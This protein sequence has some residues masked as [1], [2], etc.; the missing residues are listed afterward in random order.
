MVDRVIKILFLAAN[1]AST[2]RLTLDVEAR[3]IEQKLRESRHR[4]AFRCEQRWAVTPSD[5]QHALLDVSPD[6][7]HFSGHATA[8]HGLIL[9]SGRQ[10]PSPVGTEALASLFSIVNRDVRRVR[11]VVLNACESQQQAQAL[12]QYVDCV[13]AMSASISDEAA[14]AF[15]AAFYRALGFGKSVSDAFDLARNAI[16]LHNLGAA[17]V[18]VL[19][20]RPGLAAG[21]LTLA[22][23][24]PGELSGA[25]SV[26]P[27]S[28]PPG[29]FAI[30][31]FQPGD[32]LA[33]GRFQ[34][35][36][37]LGQGAFATVWRALDHQRGD[38]VA[39]KVLHDRYTRDAVMHDRFFR[40]AAMLTRL[41][42]PQ[43]VGIREPRIEADGHQ[44][45]VMDFVRGQTLL[46]HVQLHH[47]SWYAIVQ[48]LL[49]IG[50]ALAYAHARACIHRDVKP[51]NILIDQRGDAH[52]ID[53]D[54]VRDLHNEGGTMPGQMGTFHF[55]APEL[56]DQPQNADPRADQYGLAMTIAAAIAGRP[57]ERDAK[58]DSSDYINHLACPPTVKTIL[59]RGTA[60]DPAHRYASVPE[61]CRELRLLL[62]DE[63]LRRRRA[64][65]RRYHPWL[66]A[67]TATAIGLGVFASMAADDPK[68][69][70]PQP[71]PA[72]EPTRPAQREGNMPYRPAPKAI[73][74]AKPATSLDLQ[75]SLTHDRSATLV[76]LRLS[77]DNTLG[78]AQEKARLAAQAG[79][80]PFITHG[81]RGYYYVYVGSYASETHASQDLPG[82]RAILGKPA[83]VRRLR[84]ECPNVRWTPQG[85]HECY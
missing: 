39:I 84:N 26:V 68:D 51:A 67:G 43:I 40:G 8:N 37:W 14:I 30:P 85:I 50:E 4:D 9:D 49:P 59:R 80:S 72:G 76:T 54:L 22:L 18:P 38:E 46:E 79:Y 81:E 16:Q 7:V 5:L 36:E 77:A 74:P 53:F 41:P 10:S 75:Q 47:P 2:A 29:R 13:I 70:S 21:A 58:R 60:W 44:F 23:P 31:P 48:M 65:R 17:R 78:E 56:L 27:A 82:A 62:I 71:P 45:Y 69:S 61:L 33:G 12:C 52:L 6:I 11:I 34:I 32:T 15:S 66:L 64:N 55:A 25:T 42:H 3:E 20:I 73:T 83:A 19:L 1:P 57:P 63:E 28:V 35:Q 24:V